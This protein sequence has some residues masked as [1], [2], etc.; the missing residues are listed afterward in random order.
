[1]NALN[2]R[3]SAPWTSVSL[4]Y[5]ALTSA[6]RAASPV[7]PTARASRARAAPRSGSLIAVSTACWSTVTARAACPA[8]RS[9]LPCICNAYAENAGW[10]SRWRAAVRPLA[11]HRVATQ[12]RSSG[13]TVPR[14]TPRLTHACPSTVK[15]ACSRWPS[16]ARASSRATN[17]HNSLT[18]SAARPADRASPA[19]RIVDS[20]NATIATNSLS[21]GSVTPS[22][23]EGI[24]R[25]FPIYRRVAT[26]WTARR[27][28]SIIEM[29]VVS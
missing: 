15:V 22:R 18:D 25:V 6:N 28:V 12:R 16:A 19:R 23:C 13:S 5:E 27:P 10:Q 8:L 26:S 17:G 11:V 3:P 21:A 24:A 1:M 20:A 14:L 2:S 7:W 9:S 4:W 29:Y